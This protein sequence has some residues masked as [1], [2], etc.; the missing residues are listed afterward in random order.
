MLL[1]GSHRRL[2]GEWA[3]EWPLVVK[4]GLAQSGIHEKGI[5]FQECQVKKCCWALRTCQALNWKARSLG[6]ATV[7]TPKET[8]APSLHKSS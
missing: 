1:P 8:P 2:L 3:C 7:E 6:T 5:Q 4:Y